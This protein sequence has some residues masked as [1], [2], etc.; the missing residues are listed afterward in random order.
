MSL[1]LRQLEVFLA[2]AEDCNFRRTAQRLAI[3]QPSVSGRIK[4]LESYLGYE[5][6]DR[7]S[8]TIPRLTQQGHT[9]LAKAKQMVGGANQLTAPRRTNTA[10]SPLRLRAAIGPM[11][12]KQRV[13]PALP[14]FCYEHAEIMTEIAPLAAAGGNGIDLI[15]AGSADIC[16]YTGEPPAPEANIDIEVLGSISCSILGAPELVARVGNTVEAISA[17][18]FILAPE[19]HSAACWVRA[20]LAEVGISPSNVVARPQFPEVVV[21]MIEDGAGLS[22]FYDEFVSDRALRRIGPALRP[23]GRVMLKGFRARQPGAAPLLD[24]LRQVSVPTGKSPCR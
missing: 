12:L 9:F 8:G 3:S 13:M 1:T 23:T 22:V 15:R 18:P 11:L 10:S 21:Q 6:F 24:F 4:S 16:V 5:L 20:R 2:A 14:T 19:H 17:A 7:A